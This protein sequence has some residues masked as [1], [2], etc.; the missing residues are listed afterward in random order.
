MPVAGFKVGGILPD[1]Y[2]LSITVFVQDATEENPV[3]GGAP[4]KLATTG[5]Y[6]AARCTD[7]DA[8]QLTAKHTIQS[9]KQPLGAFAYG[10]SR[11]NEFAYTGTLAVGDSIVANG[12]GGVKKA[13]AA[14]GT[15]VVL[16]DTVK[17]IAEVL[18]P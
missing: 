10:F 14:N 18:L 7:G 13:G 3:K 4:L 2:G 16:V 1:D 15:Y 8:I 9:K 17:K 6:H 11:N 5:N 12:T